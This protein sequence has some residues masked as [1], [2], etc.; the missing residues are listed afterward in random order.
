MA[1]GSPRLLAA[2]PCMWL[3]PPGA[4]AQPQSAGALLVEVCL[5]PRGVNARAAQVLLQ[6]GEG[7]EATLRLL[8]Y[9]RHS[10]ELLQRRDWVAADEAA[11]VHTHPRFRVPAWDSE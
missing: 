7:L 2:L 4:E 11:S 9:C 3:L 6:A 1:G 5:P 10:G 8:V